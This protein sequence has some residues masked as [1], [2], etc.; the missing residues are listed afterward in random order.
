MSEENVEFAK[1]YVAAFNAGGLVAVG[2]MWHPDIEVLDPP[3]F[4]DAGRH[5]G[6]EAALK[7]VEGYLEVGW[8]GQFH[9]PEFFDAGD[10]V[11]V[12]WKARAE[13]PHE[14]LALEETFSH[15][16]LFEA[17][18][19]RRVRQFIGREEGLEAAGLTE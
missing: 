12:L 4:P 7:A 15:L 3:T 18:K 16:Y 13:A 5:T 10:E 1:Q 2:P 19:L 6:A 11:L 14:G 17:G 8:D 9:G